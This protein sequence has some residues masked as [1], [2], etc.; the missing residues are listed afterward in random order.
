MLMTTTNI[1]PCGCCG[2]QNCPCSQCSWEWHWV[3]ENTHWQWIPIDLCGGGGGES[4][5]CCTCPSPPYDGEYEGHYVIV[6]CVG[7]NRCSCCECSATWDAFTETWVVSQSCVDANGN[8]C[9]NCDCVKPTTP[10]STHGEL[11]GPIP[12]GCPSS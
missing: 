8:A 1:G 6:D 7:N 10:G 5:R 4:E 3:A 11:S 9:G 2:G 12:C